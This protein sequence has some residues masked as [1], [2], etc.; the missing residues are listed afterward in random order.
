MGAKR[1]KNP[2]SKER[3]NSRLG[4]RGRLEREDPAH[5]DRPAPAPVSAT[6]LRDALA[7]PPARRLPALPVAPRLS[8]PRARAPPHPPLLFASARAAAHLEPL[9]RAARA[10]RVS[11]SSALS[12]LFGSAPRP[13]VVS[14]PLP[15]AR[16]PFA[17]ETPS[18]PS[19][20]T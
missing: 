16:A 10:P 17:P 6:R 13:G 18:A 3:K 15:L 9:S 19:A 8:A 7:V 12:P 5:G 2:R 14:L 4:A 20:K 1:K 11:V